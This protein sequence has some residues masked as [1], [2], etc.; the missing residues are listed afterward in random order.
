MKKQINPW[1]VLAEL[2]AWQERAER[3]EAQVATVRALC[4]A[5]RQE[6]HREQV[7]P[8]WTPTRAAQADAVKRAVRRVE[9]ALD[10]L[11]AGRQ[12]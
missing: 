10:G 8:R 1:T 7:T 2:V 12:G 9:A 4:D 6:A 11:P 3:A 5:L